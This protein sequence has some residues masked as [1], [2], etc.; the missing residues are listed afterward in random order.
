MK[1]NTAGHLN[2]QH[3]HFFAMPVCEQE[4]GTRYN[5]PVRCSFKPT[6]R[7]LPGQLRG[8]LRWMEFVEFISDAQ[9]P[10]VDFLLV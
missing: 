2:K 3:L 10:I 1:H 6:P 5:V 8:L 7:S 4:K 9:R